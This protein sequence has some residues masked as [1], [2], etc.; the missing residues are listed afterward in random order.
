[1]AR[2]GRRDV[3]SAAV[4]TSLGRRKIAGMRAAAVADAVR[5]GREPGRAAHAAGSRNSPGKGPRTLG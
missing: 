4:A 5:A 1:M 3:R 2:D